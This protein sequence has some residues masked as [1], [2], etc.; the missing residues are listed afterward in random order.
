MGTLLK[1]LGSPQVAASASMLSGILGTGQQALADVAGGMGQADQ[2][3][4]QAAIATNNAATTRANAA[5][6][7]A[8]G[9][10]AE[11]ALK[12]GTG[13]LRAEQRAAYAANGID[14]SLGSPIDID[15][16]TATLG[17][18][19][20]AMVHYNAARSA[21]GLESQAREFE[22]ES[23]MFRRAATNA[24]KVGM[25]KAKQTIL[26]GATSLSSRWSQFKQS[27]AM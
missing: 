13:R 17:A 1:G 11:S 18:M 12:M 19:D 2:Y 6:E 16:S 7:M 20:A 15:N 27:G 25:S 26:S 21:F 4:Y 23:S 8:A 24:K 10:Y 14:V 9:G 3:A 22:E 5:A